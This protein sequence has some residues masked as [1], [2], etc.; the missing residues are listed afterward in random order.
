MQTT[1]S[2]TLNPARMLSV[3]AGAGINVS[4]GT[5]TYAGGIADAPTASGSGSLNK[6]GPGTLVLLGGN[7][8]SGATT[9]SGGVLTGSGAL[10]GPLVVNNGGTVVPSGT[11]SVGA[12]TLNT[13]GSLAF[14]VGTTADT[15]F[16][17][18][19]NL[20]LN[21]G[22]NVTV[23]GSTLS[24]ST[25]YTLAPYGGTLT[26]NSNNFHNWAVSG[27]VVPTGSGYRCSFAF[28]AIFDE[29]DLVLVAPA[30]A[31][32][33]TQSIGGTF[34]WSNTGYWSFSSGTD[35]VPNSRD[36][37]AIFGLTTGTATVN[38]NG[39]RTV[40]GLT[41]SNTG[42]SSYALSRTDTTSTLTLDNYATPATLSNSGSNNSINVPLVLNSNLNIVTTKNLTIS[43]PISGGASV[44]LNGAGTVIL[45]S[46]ANNYSSGTFINAGVLQLGDNQT[47]NGS[48]AGNITDN[49]TLMFDNPNA[50]TFAG[51]ISGTGT[52]YKSGTG[53]LT[54]TGSNTFSGLLSLTAGTLNIGGASAVGNGLF[55]I[56]INTTIVNTSGAALTLPNNPE[57]WT[58]NFTFAGSN[59]LNLGT[60]NVSLSAA[61]TVT[62]T[63]NNLTVGGAISGSGF[64]L[65]KT[66]AGTLTLGGADTYTGGTIISSSG[67]LN[68]NSASALGTGPFTVNGGTVG[69][70][71]GNS[72]GHAVTLSTTGAETWNG[73]I[74]FA[75][76]NDL[77]LGTGAV[78]ITSTSGTVTVS[79]NKLTI[80][81]AISST[82]TG[83]HLTK[84]GT[85]TLVL[86]G[87]NTYTGGTTISAGTLDFATP[88]ASP[89]SGVLTFGKGAYVALGNLLG[90]SAPAIADGDADQTLPGISSSDASDGQGLTSASG[91][92][93]A[94]TATLGGAPALPQGD[95]G[96]A[97]GG[98]QPVPE[99]G[100]IVLLLVG[101]ALAVA[102]SK[103]HRRPRFTCLKKVNISVSKYYAIVAS[104]SRLLLPLQT[105]WRGP[106]VASRPTSG[107]TRFV[108]SAS[109]RRPTS[110]HKSL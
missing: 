75:G 4:A 64:S 98:P 1:A 7:T 85:G 36:D 19:N 23:T 94:M 95:A 57:S 22:V 62:V 56:G 106:T 99:P 90:A 38:L 77:N 3:G 84:A 43:Q 29:L 89:T 49:G 33:W 16:S 82:S 71:I 8:Y 58:G 87:S 104:L 101:A 66:G 103:R 92:S 21:P 27:A 109:D 46:T 31:G 20:T 55:K 24:P 86:S 80:G 9:V 79:S 67:Q 110:C 50:Q 42:S 51:T 78:S 18:A 74:I 100:T 107:D 10:T 63:S 108:P 13:G 97:V 5:L 45:T 14:T 68:I 2:L 39:S 37:T 59:D 12:L 93:D 60:G 83:F 52:V 96:S 35:T 6:T 76:S 61:R 30:T 26:D 25:T 88:A 47:K 105:G 102:I 28:G 53:T 34:S 41:F 65:T 91:D 17:V 54:L 32:T 40:S 72:S 48:V 15:A 70:T 44:S 69:G 73:N 11:V 81:G